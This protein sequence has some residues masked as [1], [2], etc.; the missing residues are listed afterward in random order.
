RLIVISERDDE[1][2]FAVE[3]ASVARGDG[4]T[5]AVRIR[6]PLELHE[7]DRGSE[8]V[9]AVVEPAG[10]HVVRM[11]VPLVTGPGERG[12]AVRAKKAY[13]CSELVVIGDEHPALSDRQVLVREE[14]EAPDLPEGPA[15]APLP[16][17]ARC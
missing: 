7:A 17:C 1:A 12:H 4:G 3:V 10:L 2:R 13:T 8:L 5:C 14:A 9:E 11:G 15:Q 6:E 16:G